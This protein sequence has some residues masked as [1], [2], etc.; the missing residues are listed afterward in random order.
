MRK[1]SSPSLPQQWLL[2]SRARC[3]WLLSLLRTS[4]SGLLVLWRLMWH[5]LFCYKV[6]WELMFHFM[7]EVSAA[8]GSWLES[9]SDACEG[10]GM[11]PPVSDLEQPG[12]GPGDLQR[13]QDASTAVL[14]RLMELEA[15]VKYVSTELRA[16]KLLWS[17][18]Y[19]ELL[20]EQQE[21]HQQFQ[22]WGRSQGPKAKDMQSKAEAPSLDGTDG[23]C[24]GDSGLRMPPAPGCPGPSHTLVPGQPC[25]VHHGPCTSGTEPRS[26]CS[27]AG[28]V[29]A[30]S[31]TWG[32][33]PTRPSSPW[34]WS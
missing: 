30:P 2:R 13:L 20:R 15:E 22:E 24:M 11:C 4:L 6:F 16:E 14:E 23:W 31:G 10:D 26:C 33:S 19:L 17:S 28:L 1:P 32:S 9:G 3:R 12:A 25:H 7:R 27:Q 29:W 5:A 8:L 18:R 34:E 21:L